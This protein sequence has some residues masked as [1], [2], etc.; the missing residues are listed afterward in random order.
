MFKFNFNQF[1]KY[2]NDYKYEKILVATYYAIRYF[3][4]ALYLENISM[5]PKYFLQKKNI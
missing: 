1:V 3:S 5:I 4:T 2:M